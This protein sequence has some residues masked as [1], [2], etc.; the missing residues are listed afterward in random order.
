M[1]SQN[2]AARLHRVVPFNKIPH[3]RNRAAAR[4]INGKILKINGRSHSRAIGSA[5][6]VAVDFNPRMFDVTL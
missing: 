1:V 3:D 6:I 4:G 5:D 2:A